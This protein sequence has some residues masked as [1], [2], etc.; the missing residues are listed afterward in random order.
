[1]V[2]FLPILEG[3]RAMKTSLL[4]PLLFLL[5]I[6]T[7]NVW[8]WIFSSRGKDYPIPPIEYSV[9]HFTDLIGPQ[10]EFIEDVWLVPETLLKL[11]PGISYDPK[12]FSRV[13]YFYRIPTKSKW[14]KV[15]YWILESKNWTRI[16][17]GGY[18]G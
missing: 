8:C 12:N 10:K 11:N 17:N 6:F 18:V 9:E 16:D 1:L 7:V 5:T 3:G 2:D 4:I 14:E 15:G 13:F